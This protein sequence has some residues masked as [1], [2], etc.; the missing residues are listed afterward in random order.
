LDFDY[1]TNKSQSIHAFVGGSG[2]SEC[3]DGTVLARPYL[4]DPTC[5]TWLKTKGVLLD[6]INSVAGGKMMFDYI[7]RNDYNDKLL[8]SIEFYQPGNLSPYKAFNFQYQHSS[9]RPFLIELSEKGRGGSLAKT[10]NFSYNDMGSLPPRLSYA[11]DHWGYFN[12]K[13]NYILIP[14][15]THPIFK[16]YLPSATANREPD[17]NYSSKGLLASITYPTGGK[18]SIV[19]EGNEAYAYTTTMPTPIDVSIST[20]VSYDPGTPVYSSPFVVSFLQQ[21]TISGSCNGGYDP[22]TSSL[23]IS[24]LDAN[25]DAVYNGSGGYNSTIEEKILLNPGTYKIRIIAYTGSSGEATLNYMPGSPSSQLM[26]VNTGGARV[27]KVI[28]ADNVSSTTSVKTYQYSK[29][30]TP[31]VSSGAPP[32]MPIYEKATK[33]SVA[34]PCL[35]PVMDLR[36][37]ETYYIM[38]SNSLQNLYGYSSG[39]T[40]YSSVVESFGENFE[41][42]GIEHEFIVSGN[43]GVEVV[44]GESVMGTLSSSNDW[45]NGKETYRHVFKN[46][47]TDFVSVKKVFT[48]YSE[49]PRLD[50]LQRE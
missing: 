42:G 32:M 8:S 22:A 29:L 7:D 31:E 38:Y 35:S 50:Q 13:N 2:H 20:G 41:N 27:A 11:Q 3:L 10:H 49:D 30:T 12:G 45:K 44:N 40:T 18:D 4:N 26:N 25:D 48:D 39:A 23:Q 1:K 14:V 47:G 16:Q 36:D 34:C 9:E 33:M 28:I 37:F 15:P 46:V 6:E 17:P 43:A 5:L 24:I 19:Y 21:V